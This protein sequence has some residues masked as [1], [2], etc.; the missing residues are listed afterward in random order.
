MICDMWHSAETPGATWISS[1]GLATFARAP[2]YA[3]ML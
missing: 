2:A 1:N 3:G